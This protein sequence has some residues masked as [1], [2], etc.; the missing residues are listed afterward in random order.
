MV[1]LSFAEPTGK[2]GTEEKTQ[3][4]MLKEDLFPELYDKLNLSQFILDPEK[5]TVDIPKLEAY[6]RKLGFSAEPR[7]GRRMFL[8]GD[9]PHVLLD[10]GETIC[11]LYLPPSRH[12][13][14][15]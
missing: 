5:G 1:E 11:I 8:D 9:L 2:R 6:L 14:F 7:G 15:M 3:A 13:P 12:P 4:Q 10:L